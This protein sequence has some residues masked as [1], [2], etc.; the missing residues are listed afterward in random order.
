V[1]AAANDVGTFR[2]FA[3][4]S[5]LVQS[6]LERVIERSYIKRYQPHV[7][8]GYRRCWTAVGSNVAYLDLCEDPGCSVNG[9]LIELPDKDLEK[10]DDW[11]EGYE[12]VNVSGIQMYISRPE[13]RH[14]GAFVLRSYLRLVETALGAMLPPV[15]NEL[16]ILEDEQ[17]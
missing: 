3:Y 17:L 11:E 10:V 9:S 15:P 16:R 8:H 13:S 7:M 14:G 2:L 4:G 5:L 6:E 12:R 1:Q